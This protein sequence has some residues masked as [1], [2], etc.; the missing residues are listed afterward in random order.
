MGGGE[1][2]EEHVSIA[3]RIISLSLP[4]H[5]EAGT[6]SESLGCHAKCASLAV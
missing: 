4:R 5:F 3:T 1:N 2:W 6:I